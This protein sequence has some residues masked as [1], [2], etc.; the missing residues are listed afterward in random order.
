[1]E[2]LNKKIKSIINSQ[3]EYK[4]LCNSL[5]GEKAYIAGGFIRNSILTKPINDIDI[6]VDASLT[7]LSEYLNMIEQ[8]GKLEYSPFGAPRWFSRENNFHADI[9]PF[10]NFVIN[11]KE[12]SSIEKILS[13]F[14]ITINAIAYD[15]KKHILIN[16]INGLE[17]IDNK[18]IRATHF[19]FPDF[20]I[21]SSE[22]E[23]S[24]LSYF[25]FRL[26]HYK[27]ILGFSFE[28]NTLDWILSNNFRY[29]DL[30]EFKTIFFDPII[31]P[32]LVKNY[33][34]SVR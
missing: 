18:I 30:K 10:S 25:W 23:I 22:T 7:E 12:Y 19:D 8:N 28:K 3:K 24:S 6:F 14:D 5:I 4:L 31:D 13:D 20:L 11:K 29:K 16:P 34:D 32:I 9:V 1:M 33:Y 15:I 21:K 27:E 26:V 17:D 2:T